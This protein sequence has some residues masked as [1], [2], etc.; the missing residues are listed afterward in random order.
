M[1]L[2]VASRYTFNGPFTSTVHLLEDSGVYLIT[3]I[4]N[5]VHTVIDI[6]ESANINDRVTNH[7]RREQWIQYANRRIIHA[8]TFYCDE[9]TRMALELELRQLFNPVCGVR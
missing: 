3:V 9:S 1:P 8:S 6:G 2:N 4:E 5:G 7:D